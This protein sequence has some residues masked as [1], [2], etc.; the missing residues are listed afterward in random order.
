[1]WMSNPGRIGPFFVLGLSFG[2]RIRV[3]PFG[4]QA[5]DRELVCEPCARRPVELDVGRGQEHAA[6][7][8]DADIPQL[9]LAEDRAVDPSDMNSK[10]R[11]VSILPIWSTMKR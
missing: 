10:A 11:A 5:V 1:M 6:L 9:R 7:V 8:G 2:A 4:G 3:D